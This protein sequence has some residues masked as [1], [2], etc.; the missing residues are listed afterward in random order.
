MT[1]DMF[2][3]S[4]SQS[5][6]FHRSWLFTGFLAWITW[7]VNTIRAGTAYSYIAPDF[8]SGFID[9]FSCVP[10]TYSIFR[11]Q[12]SVLWTMVIV[13]YFV[14][15]F[16]RLPLFHLHLSFYNLFTRGRGRIEDYLLCIKLDIVMNTHEIVATGR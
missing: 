7:Q 4:R 10:V 8:N 6:Q 11:F 2:R 9:N 5:N 12:C 1:T 14:W 16:Y 13:F 3:L 15:L